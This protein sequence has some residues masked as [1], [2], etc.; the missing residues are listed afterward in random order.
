[1]RIESETLAEA[2]RL[3][4]ESPLNGETLQTILEASMRVVPARL[5]VLAIPVDGDTL[6]VAAVVGAPARWL[7]TRYATTQGI[8]GRASRTQELTT[9]NERLRT[10]EDRLH[11]VVATA[12]VA[13]FALDRDGVFTLSEGSALGAL[14]LRSGE[15]LGRS[16][17]EI[18]RDNPDI[19]M[20][21]R[22]ALD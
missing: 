17:F 15:V 3:V 12:P 14:G 5:A 22:R 4:A 18:Y 16:V 20:N 1:R 6:E 7:G 8:A 11:A 13:L 2:A 9:A 21:V 10:S 19:L